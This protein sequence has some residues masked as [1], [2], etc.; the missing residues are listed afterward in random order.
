[1]ADSDATSPEAIAAAQE[2]ADTLGILAGTERA[3]GPGIRLHIE[4]GD[5]QVDA[6]VLLDT[7]QELR[8]AGAEA[9]QIMDQRVISTSA[10]RCVGNTLILQGRVYS[11]PFTITAVGDP[12]K[13][14]AALEAAYSAAR[15]GLLTPATPPGN[16]GIYAG[17]AAAVLEET[18]TPVLVKIAPD[19]ADADI[20][21]RREQIDL[22]SFDL[23]ALQQIGGVHQ[24]G[25]DGDRPDV[26]QIGLSDGRPMDL[27]RH[28][29]AKHAVI[30]LC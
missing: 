14:K 8:D 26:V 20:D 7:I 16:M 23:L 12:V 25:I 5:G 18:S 30:P 15:D 10:V 13:L 27:R 24:I 1:M 3:T 22:L 29:G 11:P 2:R 9:M 21:A 6:A 4:D 28:H 19:L 17:E